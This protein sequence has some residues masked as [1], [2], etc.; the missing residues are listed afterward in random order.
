MKGDV[1]TV[2]DLRQQIA[3]LVRQYY[4]E[5]FSDRTFNPES[6][7]AHYAGRVFDAV[8]RYAAALAAAT[9]AAAIA[10]RSASPTTYGGIA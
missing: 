4:V 9:M 5:Q 7:L 2:N 6:D 8:L 1:S 3:S 10:A